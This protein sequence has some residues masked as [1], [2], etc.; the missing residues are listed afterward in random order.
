MDRSTGK[1][2]GTGGGAASS[3][4]GQLPTTAEIEEVR[5]LLCGVLDLEFDAEEEVALELHF[6]CDF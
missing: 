1:L 6:Q 2:S 4:L 5:G 3:T